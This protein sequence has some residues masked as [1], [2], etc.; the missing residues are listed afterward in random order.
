MT[1]AFTILR[2]PEDGPDI[3]YCDTPAGPMYPEKDEEIARAHRA[4]AVL[5]AAAL[6]E[7]EAIELVAR[8]AAAL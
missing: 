3:V 1:G 7:R 8:Y 4:F 5:A 2:Y 6:P